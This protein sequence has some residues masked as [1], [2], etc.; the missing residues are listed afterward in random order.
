M[1]IAIEWT[2]VIFRAFLL[3]DG[4]PIVDSRVT[5]DGAQGLTPGEFEAVLRANIEDWLAPDRIVLISGMATSRTGWRQSPF[6]STPAAVGDIA[7]NAVWLDVEGTGGLA[8]LPG[9]AVST[10][11]PDVMRSEEIRIFGAGIDDEAVVILPGDHPKWVKV[12]GGRI[13][14]FWTF[15]TGEMARL[16]LS[17]SI[18]SGLVPQDVDSDEAGFKRGIAEAL[19]TGHGGGM[20]RRLF[21]SR[22]LVLFDKLAP[23]QIPSYLKGL[24]LTAEAQ[25]ALEGIASRDSRVVILE[26]GE[27]ARDY[28]KVLNA[29]GYRDV[30]LKNTDLA[31]GFRRVHAALGSCRAGQLV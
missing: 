17:D 14:A 30:F 13:A 27:H 12:E 3:E 1:F 5:G 29:L 8:F 4:G 7:A 2:S 31:D 26:T 9:V 23:E 24:A 15:V 22:S 20:L 16:L 21:S 6:A 10:G 11:L 18:L 19:E 28:A 25:E